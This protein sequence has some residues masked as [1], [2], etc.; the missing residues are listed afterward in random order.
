MDKHFFNIHFTDNENPLI[1]KAVH[2]VFCNFQYFLDYNSYVPKIKDIFLD[3]AQESKIF[4]SNKFRHLL[5]SK[6]FKH[7]L[8]FKNKPLLIE[9]DRED[10]IGTCFYMI[11]SL[12]EYAEIE[13]D[14]LDR[15][16]QEKTYQE[17]FDCYEE[18]LVLKY[19][20]ELS[21]QIF[22]EKIPLK[23]SSYFLSH[24][25]DFVNSAWKDELK[26]ALKNA[27]LIEA[28]RVLK[29]HLN[30]LDSWQNIEKIIQAEREYGIHSSFFWLGSSE[31]TK[32]QN[33]KNADYK[34]SDAYIQK[35]M[36]NIEQ[37][38]LHENGI[39][40]SIGSQSFAEEIKQLSEYQIKKN[41][42]HYLKFSISSDYPK[43]A[44][45]KLEY[46]CSLGFSKSI[47]FR[48]SYGLPFKAMNP[49]NFEQY[50]FVSLPLNIMDSSL[51]YYMKQDS[52]N[53]VLD[54]IEKFIL[55]NSHSTVI[56]LCSHNN[57]YKE[58]IYKKILCLIKNNLEWSKY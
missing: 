23:K 21:L 15:F 37:S 57:L 46:E 39:H 41:R 45:T 22:G 6:N 19:F 40:K 55:N 9:D 24:D 12:Q 7:E 4:L 18:N 33:V 36:L 43:F 50:Q 1:K 34:I 52:G 31:L 35:C 27:K 49:I 54:Q 14:Y 20:Q 42:Y 48:N 10:Y 32:F 2:N 38:D 8:W 25:I 47:G 5:L 17:K 58:D 3:E 53:K 44:N 11:N 56:G 51:Y 13:T 26:K 29:K 28:F 16:P 30:G